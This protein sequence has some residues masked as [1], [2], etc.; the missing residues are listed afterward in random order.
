MSRGG[1]AIRAPHQIPRDPRGF[2]FSRNAA[3]THLHGRCASVVRLLADYLEHNLPAEEHAALE[4]HLS[5]CPRCVTQLKTYESTLSL[6]HSICEDDL[7][8]EL[9]CT[10]RSFLHRSCGN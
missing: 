4:R 3:V 6:L 10:L 1:A 2:A 9:R 7:P 8:P 5:K